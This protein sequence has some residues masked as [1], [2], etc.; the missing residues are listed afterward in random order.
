M[1]VSPV[2]NNLCVHTIFFHE[3]PQARATSVIEWA[4]QVVQVIEYGVILMR[5]CRQTVARAWAPAEDI[6]LREHGRPQKTFCSSFSVCWPCN[7]NGRT[8]KM[9]NVTATVTYSVFP[10]RKFYTEKL[11]VLVRMDIL[12]MDI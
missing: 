12:R 6:L 5:C 1:S 9:S 8:Q 10:I 3:S 7:A 2:Q 11:F 4:T